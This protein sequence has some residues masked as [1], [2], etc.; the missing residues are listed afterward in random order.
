MKA[1]IKANGDLEISAE[2]EIESY[3]LTKWSEDNRNSDAEIDNSGLAFKEG[4]C[5]VIKPRLDAEKEIVI[6]QI[7]DVDPISKR[8]GILCGLKVVPCGHDFTRKNE[9]V[10]CEDCLKVIVEKNK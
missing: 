8:R 10:T 6:H 9:Q 7:T 4:T 5:L 3:A 1:E 2:T